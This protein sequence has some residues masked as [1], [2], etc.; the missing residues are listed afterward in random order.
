MKTSITT[1]A[2]C[3]GLSLASLAGASSAAA[4]GR[5]VDRDNMKGGRTVGAG[6]YVAAENGGVLA[7]RRVV[8]S[9]DQ[10]NVSKTSG[11]LFRTPNGGQGG[12]FSNTVHGAD[13]SVQHQSGLKASGEK[14][15]VE[16]NGGYQRDANGNLTQ[17]RDTAI[18]NAQTGNTYQGN[19]QYSKEAGVSHSAT[20]FDGSGSE[21]ACPS[22]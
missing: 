4:D 7:Q 21:I 17:N 8:R 12:R 6:R 5:H 19:T 13:G 1:M 18:T 2:F 9:D 14:G 15:G 20:C 3:F 10:G 22:R 11:G 16:T